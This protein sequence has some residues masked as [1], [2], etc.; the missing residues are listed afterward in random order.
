MHNFIREG[1]DL[2]AQPFEALQRFEEQFLEFPEE[3]RRQHSAL[4]LNYLQ[5]YISLVDVFGDEFVDTAVIGESI[6]L[7]PGY[8]E[9]ISEIPWHQKVGFHTSEAN[10]ILKRIK[11]DLEKIREDV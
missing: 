4:E 8:L 10:K 5:Q 9:D 1:V 2:S 11:S 7:V 6:K 3:I